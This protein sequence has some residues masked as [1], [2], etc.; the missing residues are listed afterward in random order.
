LNQGIA[1]YCRSFI[2]AYYND[3][4]WVESC[5]TLVEHKDGQL[6]LLHWAERYEASLA[7]VVEL[8]GLRK[9]A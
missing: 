9:T 8:P 1:L 2:A 7:Q 3:G 5:T 4:D 6:E